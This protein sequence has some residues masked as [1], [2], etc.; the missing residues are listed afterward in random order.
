MP[1]GPIG[2][3]TLVT[4]PAARALRSGQTKSR[5]LPSSERRRGDEQLPHLH[6]VRRKERWRSW[7]AFSY[8]GMI[9][10]G[11]RRSGPFGKSRSLSIVS[12]SEAN[13]LDEVIP[14]TATGSPFTINRQVSSR[15]RCR[16][17]RLVDPAI[18]PAA[19]ARG[20]RT[21]WKLVKWTRLQIA[22]FRAGAD[23]LKNWMVQSHLRLMVSLMVFRFITLINY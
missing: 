8:A 15:E 23:I 19:F 10:L 6:P 4:S 22:P 2:R 14:V 12:A 3:L 11:T 17:Q 9:G 7:L 18:C 21:N 1:I 13:R 5:T 20:T 16:H